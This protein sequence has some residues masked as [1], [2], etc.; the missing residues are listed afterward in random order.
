M[1]VLTL[2]LVVLTLAIAVPTIMLVV[3][4]YKTNDSPIMVVLPQNSVCIN[5]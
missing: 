1:L 5:S 2:V 3:K 4:D